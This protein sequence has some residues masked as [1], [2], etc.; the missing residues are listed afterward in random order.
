MPFTLRYLIYQKV[1][2]LCGEKFCLKYLNIIYQILE[3]EYFS[4]HGEVTNKNIEHVVQDIKD[5]CGEKT[6]D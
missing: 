5:F 6:Y 4:I 2:S 1:R 3:E